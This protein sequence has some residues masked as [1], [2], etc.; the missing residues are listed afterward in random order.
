MTPEEEDAGVEEG[1]EGRAEVEFGVV[2]FAAADDLGVLEIDHLVPVVGFG[3]SPEADEKSGEEEDGEE[4]GQG[5]IAIE[6]EVRGQNLREVSWR[7]GAW[8]GHCEIVAR[9]GWLQGW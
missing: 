4:D 1:K 7:L 6:R 9:G 2:D 5:A 3:H 8:R